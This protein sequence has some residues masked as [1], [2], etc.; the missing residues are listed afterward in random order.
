MDRADTLREQATKFRELAR[1]DK[2]GTIRE[3][4]LALASQCEELASSIEAS[5][6]RAALHLVPKTE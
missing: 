1:T 2:A 4:L 3:K 5:H 6:K